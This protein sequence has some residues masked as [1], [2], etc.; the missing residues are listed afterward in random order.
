[1]E[2]P[3]EYRDNLKKGIITKEM[4]EDCL[5]SV[6]KRAKN[7]R[8][9]ER[10]YRNRYRHSQY[11]TTEK[12]QQKKEYYYR[13]K[14][15]LLSLLI[16]DCIHIEKQQRRLTIREA[17]ERYPTYDKL[18]P[19][20][21]RWD[22]SGRYYVVSIPGE[23]YYLFYRLGKHS[24]HTPILERELTQYPNLE[25]VQIEGLITH[26]EDILDL[27]SVQFVEKILELIAS[28]DYI[29]VG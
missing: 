7:C 18:Y 17:D 23:R 26:G 20:V 2:T 14:E 29:Y 16:L 25:Q 13:Q 1:M 19:V 28:E 22:G 5:F 11:D 12:Y 3:K 9:K 27:L 24:F 4:L 15:I 8:N 6:N 10:E 21:H